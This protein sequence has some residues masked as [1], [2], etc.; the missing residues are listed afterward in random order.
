MHRIRLKPEEIGF[1]DIMNT[2]HCLNCGWHGSESELDVY[3]TQS[4]IT[5][6]Y[7]GIEEYSCPHCYTLLNTKAIYKISPILRAQYKRTLRR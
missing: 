7:Y 2:T 1:Q 6:G 5:I 4:A 3:R